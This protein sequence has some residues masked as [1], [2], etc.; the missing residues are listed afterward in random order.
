MKTYKHNKTNKICQIINTQAAGMCQ[1]T[2]GKTFIIYKY[3]DDNLNYP[4]IM[5]HKEFYNTHS[6]SHPVNVT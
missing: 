3:N 1:N 2:I 4:F 6:E 5:E